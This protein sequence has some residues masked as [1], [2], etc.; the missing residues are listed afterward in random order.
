MSGIVCAI[1]GGASS[2][3]TI[4]RAVAMAKETGLPLY[5]LYVL[6]LDF[7]MQT[8]QARTQ[9]ISEEMRELGEFILLAAQAQAERQGVTAEGVI[10]EGH[11]VGDEIIGLCREVGAD[12]VVLGRPREA[13]AEDVFTHEQLDQFG[14]H[15]ERETGTRVIYPEGDDQ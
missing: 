5:F 3:P 7:L 8:G 15:I 6:N 2:R 12:C 14:R 9:T 13:E 4:N 10:R 11:V 1:R